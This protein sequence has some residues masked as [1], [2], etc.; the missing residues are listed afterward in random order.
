MSSKRAA[1][2]SSNLNV[3]DHR[4]PVFASDESCPTSH[5]KEQ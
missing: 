3:S 5:T 4:L 2:L 1:N